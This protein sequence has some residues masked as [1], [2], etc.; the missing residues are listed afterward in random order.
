MAQRLP[1]SYC[2]WSHMGISRGTP[3]PVAPRAESA[4][5]SQSSHHH[6]KQAPLT[7][8]TAPRGNEADLPSS[9]SVGGGLLTIFKQD[10]QPHNTMSFR[11]ENIITEIKIQWVDSTTEWRG[12]KKEPVS[13]QTEQ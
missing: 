7:L 8:A 3:L 5:G 13:F 9:Y 12:Q 11:P 10:P 6:P 2:H 1:I 4:A